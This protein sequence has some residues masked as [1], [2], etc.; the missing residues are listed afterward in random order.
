MRSPSTFAARLLTVAFA[1]II[2]QAGMAAADLTGMDATVNNAAS[3]VMEQHAIRGLAIAITAQGQQRFYNYGLA[4]KATQQP[5]TRDTLF[6]VGS[7][8]KTLTAT[9]AAY[10]EAHGKLSLTNSPGRHL[11]ALQGSAFDPVLLINLA[12]HTAGAFRC[13]CPT[14]LATNSS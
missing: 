13:S 5:V 1:A 12:T 6:E 2:S 7:V 3:K 11:P 9:V 10:A 14:K 4:S 8:S